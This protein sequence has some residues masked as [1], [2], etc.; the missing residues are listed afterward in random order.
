MTIERDHFEGPIT[1][2][3]DVCGEDQPLL[4]SDFGGALAKFKSRGGKA[5]KVGDEWEHH[6]RECVE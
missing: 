3:C 6:C 5:V 4:T 2:I 1:I